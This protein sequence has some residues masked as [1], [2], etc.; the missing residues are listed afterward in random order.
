MQNYEVILKNTETVTFKFKY[1]ITAKDEE[2]A[3]LDAMERYRCKHEC[4]S[5]KEKWEE[6][7]V[8][9][10]TD[11]ECEMESV[12]ETDEESEDE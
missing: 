9:G 11:G 5:D 10:E 7:C 6:S 12:E 2:T 4:M 3:E 1:I 8:E